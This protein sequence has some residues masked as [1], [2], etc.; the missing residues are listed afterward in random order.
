L[1]VLAAHNLETLRR[2]SVPKRNGLHK[3]FFSILL[4]TINEGEIS[5]GRNSAIAV[6]VSVLLLST[7]F[8][9]DHDKNHNDAF[10][11]GQAGETRIAR[12]VRHQLLAPLLWDL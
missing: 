9:A 4:D 11:P 10:I 5:M 12:E 2:E 6:T 7:A 3:P 8:A 1:G